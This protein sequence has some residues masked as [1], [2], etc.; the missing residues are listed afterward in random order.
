MYDLEV[1]H[2]SIQAVDGRAAGA[3]LVPRDDRGGIRRRLRFVE[4]IVDHERVVLGQVEGARHLEV[5]RVHLERS[6]VKARELI[7]E[8]FIL[9][10]VRAERERER[11][12]EHA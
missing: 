3:A 7:N 2:L 11:E 5:P 8:I 12:G 9:R 4:L 6:L 1:A 10:S